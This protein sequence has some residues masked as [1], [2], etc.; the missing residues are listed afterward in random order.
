[1]GPLQ[2]RYAEDRRERPG[3]LLRGR[4]GEQLVLLVEHDVY[5]LRYSVMRRVGT[6]ELMK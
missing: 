3:S 4:S 2:T 5:S 1:M 6:L